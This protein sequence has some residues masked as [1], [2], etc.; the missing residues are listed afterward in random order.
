MAL[1]TRFYWLMIDTWVTVTVMTLWLKFG[2]GPGNGGGC[3]IVVADPLHYL[4]FPKIRR[5]LINNLWLMVVG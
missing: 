2:R 5:L 4:P 3:T 1:P